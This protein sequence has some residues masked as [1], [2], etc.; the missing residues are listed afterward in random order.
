MKSLPS[1][2]FDKATFL[3][4]LGG[5]MDLFQEVASLFLADCTRRL[6]CVREALERRDRDGLEAAAHQIKGSAGYFCAPRAYAAALKVER[7]ALAGDFVRARGACARLEQ[8]VA[9]L[10]RALTTESSA[11]SAQARLRS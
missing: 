7:L 11:V 8:E 6:L 3:Q 5:S 1:D 9:R 10:R 2:V 4:S